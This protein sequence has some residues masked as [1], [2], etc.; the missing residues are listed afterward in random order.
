MRT[1]HFLQAAALALCCAATGAAQAQ[2]PTTLKLGWPTSDGA[3]DPLAI[4]ARAFKQALEKQSGGAMQV[5]LYPNR[6]IGD[7]KQLVEGV[8]FG[9]VD[10]AVVTNAVTAQTEPAF[11]VLELPFLFENDAHVQRVLDGPVGADLAKRLAARGAVVL[12][13]FEGGFRSLI[14]NKRPVTQPADMGGVKVRVM[15]NPVYIDLVN[16]LGGAAVPMAWGETITAIQQ[17]TIDGLELP[18]A[19]IEPLKVNEFAKYLSLTQ[20]TF[21]AYELLI[22]KR[23]LDRL[24]AQQQAWVQA[25]AKEAV[26]EQRRAMAGQTPKALESLQKAGMQVNAIGDVANF[27]KAVAPVYDKARKAGQGALIDAVLAAGK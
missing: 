2:Q 6:Q 24:P 15:Q 21:T 12:G 19:L 8:R 22:G 25:A 5:Q 14:N 23:L 7:D 26:L 20:H 18:V 3:T 1:R 16:A 17:G 9:T 13:Y 10:A 4:G 27:R 11:G